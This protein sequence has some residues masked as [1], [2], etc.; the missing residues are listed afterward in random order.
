MKQ[1]AS[2]PWNLKIDKEFQPSVS[3]L[4][5]M[6]NEEKIIRLKLANLRKIKYPQDKVEVILI[7]DASTDRTL[8]EIK[9]FFNLTPWEPVTILNETI[10]R[11]KTEALNLALKQA[12]GDVIIVSDADCFWSSDILEKTLPFLS[13][14]SVGAVAG[15]ETIINDSSSLTM[16]SEIFFDKTV[17]TIRLGESKV[18]STLFLGGGFTAYKKTFLQNFDSQVDDNGTALNIVQQKARTLL[19][20]DAY[21]YTTFPTH[22]RNKIILKIRRASQTQKIFF[23]CLKLLFHNKLVLDKRIAISEIILNILNP[24]VFVAL[25][26]FSCMVVL[27]Q[28]IFALVFL[29]VF[30]PALAISKTRTILIE[31]VQNNFVLI[32]SLFSSLQRRKFRIWKPVQESRFLLNESILSQKNLI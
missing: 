27:A 10:H 17:Q 24:L 9:N 1:K 28:P 29:A 20:P 6:H 26:V 25:I 31:I 32:L 19:I 2:Q 3:I 22:W 7:N 11:G 12:T 13:D 5:P 15:K 14:P 16:R 18:H 30:A 23:R 8:D 21:F 4:V